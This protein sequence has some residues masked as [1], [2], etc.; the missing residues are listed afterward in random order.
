MP[1][2]P[3]PLLNLSGDKIA[4]GPLTE[5]MLPALYQWYNDFAM[6][7]LDS[8]IPHPQTLPSLRGDLDG[9]SRNDRRRSDFAIYERATMRLIGNVNLRD[10]DYRF[11]SAE[12]GIIIGERDCWGKGYGTETLFLILDYAFAVLGLHNILLDTISFNERAMRTYR[13][14]GFR[15][16]GRRREAYAIGNTTYDIVYM[17]CLAT[18]FHSPLPPIVTLP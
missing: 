2:T 14:V 15:E 7:L 17:D 6:V 8:G 11:R 4:L 12:V 13:R 10:I 5:A 16:I 3:T 18:E 1:E 9:L